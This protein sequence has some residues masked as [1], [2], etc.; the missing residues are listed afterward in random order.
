MP[1]F[2]LDTLRTEVGEKHLMAIG[3]L[4]RGGALTSEEVDR[5][6]RAIASGQGDIDSRIKG[7]FSTSSQI[8]SAE[9]RQHV[10]SA[11]VFHLHP[12]GKVM[13]KDVVD[14]YDRGLRWAK[15]VKCDEAQITTDEQPA[16]RRAPAATQTGPG[17][18]FTTTSLKDLL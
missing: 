4:G 10:L 14:R 9:Y 18:K 8:E 11:I 7:K 2:T 16:L 12:Y 17:R 15:D 6:N 3:N 5:I 13:T 1:L